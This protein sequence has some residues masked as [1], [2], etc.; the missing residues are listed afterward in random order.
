[1]LKLTVPII[2][3]NKEWTIP[4]VMESKLYNLALENVSSET[5]PTRSLGITAVVFRTSR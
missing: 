2:L 4:N 5:M 3:S 1:M